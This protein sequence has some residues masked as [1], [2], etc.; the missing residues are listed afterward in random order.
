MAYEFFVLG[1]TIVIG[2]A[3]TLVFERT[4]I[5][6]VILLMMFGFLLGPVFNVLDVTDSSVIVSILPF[7]STLALVV[8]LFDGGLEF[9][10]FS[11]AKAIPKSM[12]FTFIVFVISLVLVSGFTVIGL[13]WPLLHGILLGTVIGGTSGAIV[14]AMVEKSKAEKDTQSL[15]TVESTMTDALCIISAMVVVQL[16]TAQQAIAAG[17]VIGLLLSSFT[18]AILIGVVGAGLWIFIVDR[19]A[20]EKYSYM[21]MLALVFGVYAIIEMIG[22]NGGFG[23]FVFGMVLGNARRLGKLAKLDWENPINNMMR[24]FQGEVTFFV[25]TFFF[26]YIGLLLSLEY[27]TPWVLAISF[28]LVLLLGLARLLAQKALFSEAPKKDRGIIVTMMPRGLA[29]AV[30]ATIPLTTGIN[31]LNFQEMVFGVI[32]LSNLAATAGIFYFNNRH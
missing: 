29:A 17:T 6:Q 27:F 9:N 23:V 20:I 22:A 30:L 28:G 4:R 2:F 25:R 15:L 8:L 26:V 12:L 10:I 7:I 21:L 5:S 3:A 24:L 31:I 16:I 13:G 19:F 18:T 1:L 32:L 11:V 14:I